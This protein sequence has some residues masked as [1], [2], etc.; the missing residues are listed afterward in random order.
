MTRASLSS[1]ALEV[2]GKY[3]CNYE[4]IEIIIITK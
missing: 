2:I 4:L 3:D 1:G